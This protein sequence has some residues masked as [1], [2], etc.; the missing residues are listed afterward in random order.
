MTS[1]WKA[2]FQRWGDE[3]RDH[4]C[5]ALC[6]ALLSFGAAASEMIDY[7]QGHPIHVVQAIDQA[8]AT[9]EDALLWTK[10]SDG[11]YDLG[12]MLKVSVPVPDTKDSFENIWVLKVRD[13][14]AGG[15][16]GEID[17]DPVYVPDLVHGAPFT[18]STDDVIDWG[19]WGDDGMLWGNYTTRMMLDQMSEA[20]ANNFR[21][22]LSPQ[23]WPTQ[24]R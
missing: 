20:T 17:S 15:L 24:W 11:R 18:F 12:L 13:S 6:F 16:T 4:T 14:T 22:L 8:R 1:S 3:L 7:P 10:K 5:L 2:T 19:W 9:L 21:Q 23:P